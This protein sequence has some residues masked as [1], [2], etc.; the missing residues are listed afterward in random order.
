M[1]FKSKLLTLTLTGMIFIGSAVPAA[2]ADITTFNTSQN[3]IANTT[4]SNSVEAMSVDVLGPHGKQLTSVGQDIYEMIYESFRNYDVKSENFSINTSLGLTEN[5]L[6]NIDDYIAT[7]L[8]LDHPEIFWNGDYHISVAH[9]NG[10]Y[11]DEIYVT[12]DRYGKYSSNNNVNQMFT[13]F[14][15][16][17]NNI[18]SQM[19][20]DSSVQTDLDKYFWIH[21]YL[22]DNV[23]YADTSNSF[24]NYPRE[25][26][27]DYYNAYGAIVNGKTFCQGYAAAY[28]VLCDKANLDCVMI[29]GLKAGGN[30]S[31][32]VINLN[33]KWYIVDVTSD[34][35][36][37]IKY[38]CFCTNDTG[39]KPDSTCGDFFIESSRPFKFGDINGDNRY[40]AADSAI[41]QQ[42]ILDGEIY[43]Y[44]Y[45][46]FVFADVDGSKTI[47]ANDCAWIIQKVLN[48]S[49]TFPVD[50]G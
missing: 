2:A 48:A 8:S 25:I 32:N 38:H 20:D 14:E 49:T 6:G 45:S 9:K 5:M 4:Q 7:A 13:E 42:D 11:V 23:E 41:L 18:I 37:A 46:E 16:A 29:T 44:T 1:K 36:L 40:T 39:Y 12:A 10:I 22:V 50:N 47:T 30:H 15:N 17:Y 21:D 28:K 19:Y 26:Y 24:T 3:Q 43:N 31:W 33:N 34:D 35:N 27:P